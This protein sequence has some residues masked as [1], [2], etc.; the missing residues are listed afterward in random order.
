MLLFI[1]TGP[2]NTNSTV[3][4]KKPTKSENYPCN[5]C[6][7]SF[8]SPVYLASH[9]TEKH[10]NFQF[11]CTMCNE[12]FNDKQHLEKHEKAKHFRKEHSQNAIPTLVHSSPSTPIQ[13]SP[14]HEL[15]CEKSPSD[16][17]KSAFNCEI[18]QFYTENQTKLNLH[19][20]IKHEQCW[21]C[22]EKCHFSS[23]MAN[24]GVFYHL[25]CT[26]NFG[27]HNCGTCEFAAHSEE[28]LLEHQ[29]SHKM[30]GNSNRHNLIDRQRDTFGFY[31]CEKCEFATL[32][33]DS[34]LEHQINHDMQGNRILEKHLTCNVCD[35]S[36][37]N[38]EELEVHLTEKKHNQNPDSPNISAKPTIW[39][40]PPKE[41]DKSQ[42]AIPTP[43]ECS[44]TASAHFSPQHELNC[45]ICSFSTVIKLE[46][47][48][49]LA[50]VH[51]LCW[52]CKK[53]CPFHSK[54]QNS[55]IQ[56]HLKN[57]HDYQI[58]YCKQCPF[59]TLTEDCLIQHESTHEII[60]DSPGFSGDFQDDTEAFGGNG[61]VDIENLSNQDG[62]EISIPKSDENSNKV[63]EE[64]SRD[65]SIVQEANLSR[66][67]NLI[68][69]N[70][71][72]LWLD[73]YYDNDN[74]APFETEMLQTANALAPELEMDDMEVYNGMKE[75]QQ[76]ALDKLKAREILSRSGQIELKL[77]LDEQA[78]EQ[79]P[80]L[81]A[82]TTIN[83]D[84]YDT[85]D[86]LFNEVSKTINLPIGMFKLV[87][88][89]SV[90]KSDVRLNQQNLKPGQTV[91]VLTVDLS[92]VDL[93]DENSN[94][95]L[96][97]SEIPENLSSVDLGDENSNKMD[98]TND[99]LGSSEIT[100]NSIDK[101]DDN[102]PIKA[103]E[104]C[105]SHEK[106]VK[107]YECYICE[108]VF[109]VKFSVKNHVL[110]NHPTENYDH[111]KVE[112]QNFK[113][114]GCQESFEV[115]HQLEIHFADMHKEQLLDP[116][117][118]YIG[119]NEFTAANLFARKTAKSTK[120]EKVKERVQCD[121][122]KKTLKDKKLLNRH[123]KWSHT[124]KLLYNCTKPSVKN[125]KLMCKAN[126]P[127]K[128]SL[129]KH[130][131]VVHE[132]KKLFPCKECEASFEDAFSLQRHQ[133]CHGVRHCCPICDKP[134]SQ[135]GNLDAHIRK[136]H[137]CQPE[138]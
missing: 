18:C 134:F 33:E 64:L 8:N 37:E 51:D 24:S 61:M 48:F 6:E 99:L 82:F 27:F 104:K 86:D 28:S 59:V 20:A 54:V 35:F 85:G 127:R 67:R 111:K 117:K 53:R 14:Q 52:I 63:E 57:V 44:N 12:K 128:D 100:E 71:I 7:H 66:I 70:K 22:G 68:N 90:I 74:K 21:I 108:A 110:K 124:K 122:C 42:N 133:S 73:P 16:Q 138:N 25:K 135:K 55:G 2:R 106:V 9:K 65:E 126:F 112:C 78:K 87:S 137:K 69:Q 79:N 11:E 1:F 114:S 36:F 118:I 58:F 98:K 47:H 103:E 40:F 120:V 45:E 89:G 123:I 115:Y 129:E 76:I 109:M 41:K 46:L 125:P 121:I 136:E 3:S 30:K 96:G 93:A 13:F 92:S 130:I 94:D 19:L 60:L 10:G 83:I 17:S 131:L 91:M 97:G 95:L 81:G 26:H 84:A 88:A 72:K 38:K 80:D 49:H 15:S 4:S 77:K 107:A 32:S 119:E 34:L 75:L 105:K 29:I 50:M 5:Q 39:V 23:K 132:K 101:T 116:E 31:N 62:D 113:C 56:C 43:F 102:S